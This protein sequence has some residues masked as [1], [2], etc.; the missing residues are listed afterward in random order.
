MKSFQYYHIFSAR[1][2]NSK[3]ERLYVNTGKYKG[4]FCTFSR[5]GSSTK[6][7]VQ[8]EGTDDEVELHYT[9]LEQLDEYGQV[10]VMPVVDMTGRKISVGTYV[11]YSAAAGH[12]SHALAIGKVLEFTKVGAI[13]VQTLVLNGDK[14]KPTYYSTYENII[15]DPFRSLALPCDDKTVLMWMMQ[16]FDEMGKQITPDGF[17]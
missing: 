4:K 9:S 16:D 11:C 14:V 17:S 5:G 6:M 13:R 10:K 15:N 12:A 8:L 1:G 3:H 7:I 2:H